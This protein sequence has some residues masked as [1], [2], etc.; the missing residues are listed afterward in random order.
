MNILVDTSVWVEH[1]R[2]QNAVLNRLLTQ[3]SR[4]RQLD[5]NQLI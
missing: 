5:N 2:N 4:V 3:D 1:F